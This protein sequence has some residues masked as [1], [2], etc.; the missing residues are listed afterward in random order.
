M[1]AAH[2]S[3][4]IYGI[5]MKLGRIVKKRKLITWCNLIGK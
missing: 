1:H 2:N 5:G 4:T 3:K